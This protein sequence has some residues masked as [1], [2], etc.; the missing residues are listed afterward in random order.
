MKLSSITDQPITINVHI[1][2]FY[3]KADTERR[4]VLYNHNPIIRQITQII[5]NH[6]QIKTNCKNNSIKNDCRSKKYR[7][8]NR[9]NE[10]RNGDSTRTVSVQLCLFIG[11]NYFSEVKS[12]GDR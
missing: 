2:T 10:R 11:T 12:I 3:I 7:L 6:L 9:K 8:K 1:I 4:S 5:K